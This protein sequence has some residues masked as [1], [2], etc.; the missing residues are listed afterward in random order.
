MNQLYATP[1]RE[2]ISKIPQPLI[3]AIE[4]ADVYRYYDHCANAI[5]LVS[6]NIEAPLSDK[7]KRRILEH[8]IY[9]G[10]PYG[11]VFDN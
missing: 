1:D 10:L 9:G 6:K 7:E 2:F 4:R 3:K 5:H 8:C 11:I